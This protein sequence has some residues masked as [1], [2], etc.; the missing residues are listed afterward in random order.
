VQQL[1]N[2]FPVPTGPE[3]L[4]AAGQPLGYAPYSYSLANP[5]DMGAVSIRI[6]HKIHN[7]LTLFSRYNE[8]PSSSLSR[9]GNNIARLNGSVLN[10]RTL[11]LGATMVLSPR[12][13]ND[14]RFNYSRSRG[15]STAMQDDTGGA[16][17]VPSSVIVSSYTGTGLI[18][19][20]ASFQFPGLVGVSLDVRESGEAD[21][22]NR[23]INVVDTVSLVTGAHHVKFGVDYRRLMPL[24]GPRTYFQSVIFRSEADMRNGTASSLGISAQEEARPLFDNFSMY[25]QDTWKLSR[26]VTLDLGLR[27]ELN[28]PP[29]EANGRKPVLV[30]GVDNLP[31]AT[32]A[33]PDAPLYKTF[34]TAFAPRAGVAYQLSQGA[35][36]ETALRG[37]FGVYYDL[38]NAQ[39]VSGFGGFPFSRSV[40]YSNVLYP[41]SP[42]L[43][44]PPPIPQV[45]L[46]I[47]SNVAAINPDLKLPYTLQ[48]NIALEQALGANQTVTASYVAAI[49]RRLMTS[50]S[51]NQPQFVTSG[52]R[53][54]P[55]FGNI[56]Y[57]ANG[58]T[59]DYHS[60]QLQFQRRLSRGLQALVNYTW[61]HAIDELSNESVGTVLLSVGSALL[62]GNA[63][64]DVRHNLSSAVTYELPTLR[65]AGLTPLFRN[66]SVNGIVHAESGFPVDVTAG[67]L[68]NADGTSVTF[69]PDLILGV[70][71]YITDPTVP[72][73]RRF[74]SAAFRTP[75]TIPGASMPTRPG[76]FGRNV[77]RGLPLYQLDMALRRQF[78]LTE[79][80]RAELR[81]EAFNIFNHPNFGSYCP[82][83]PSP[84]T[85][86]VPL[87]MLNRSLGGLS[88]LYQ[89][90]G[91]RSMQLSLKMSF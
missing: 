78:K 24:Y 68:V 41:I 21:S 70:P 79:Q 40:S 44:A 15:K 47:I 30:V 89:I 73:G 52:P 48:W 45:R 22:Y 49:G 61:S 11:T 29:G 72:G 25:G 60:L 35:G 18:G 23:Q 83:F 62:R 66:W 86:G 64:F 14:L 54:N 10:T 2:A 58:P 33:P 16:V 55:N 81:A 76:T 56:I 59:S 84:T 28:P 27:W 37:G 82:C 69:R 80:W 85:F 36:R 13:S 26:R 75:P 46:P 4:D 50:W 43:V 1:L 71:L 39:T 77:L 65:A 19:G 32:L 5:T 3:L 87:V 9:A 63:D 67:T 6:D 34:W 57:A 7:R 88:S 31:T 74:N 51:L 17:P 20:A 42:T 38:G 91:P 12:L 53:P 8:A 90:G